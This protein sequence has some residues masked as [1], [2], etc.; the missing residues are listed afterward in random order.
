MKNEGNE[1]KKENG[2]INNVIKGTKAK[3]KAFVG[4][5]MWVKDVFLIT[6]GAAIWEG[7]KFSV[8]VI[9]E[10]SKQAKDPNNNMVDV[11]VETITFEETE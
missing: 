7:A 11:P 4:T 2:K 3:I 6:A 5:H 8:D 10:V 9:K 1:N